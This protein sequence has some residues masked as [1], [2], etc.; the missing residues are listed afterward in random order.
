MVRA[1][2]IIS[3]ATNNGKEYPVLYHSEAAPAESTVKKW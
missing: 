3:E 1:E 2:Q